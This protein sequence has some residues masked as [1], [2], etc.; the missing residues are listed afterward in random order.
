MPLTNAQLQNFVSNLR[1]NADQ[2]MIAMDGAQTI[3][4]TWAALPVYAA[5]ESA[6]VGNPDA[7]GGEHAGMTLEEIEAYILAMQEMTQIASRA[8]EADVTFAATVA[9]VSHLV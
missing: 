2:W 9:A 4:R 8:N 3:L 5:L 6:L 1:G 7:L